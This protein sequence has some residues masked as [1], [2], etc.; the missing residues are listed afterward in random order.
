MRMRLHS[1]GGWWIAK[2]S[3]WSDPLLGLQAGNVH[4]VKLGPTVR[5][6]SS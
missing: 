5:V 3:D 2:A 4:N 6:P 1:G